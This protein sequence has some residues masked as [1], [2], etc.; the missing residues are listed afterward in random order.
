MR[1]FTKIE[2]VIISAESKDD[3]NK[4][5]EALG[6]SGY[7]DVEE[8]TGEYTTYGPI[9]ESAT[10]CVYFSLDGGKTQEIEFEGTED[11]CQN[12]IEKQ[13]FQCMFARY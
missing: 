11:E 9:R 4:H 10:H 7:S 12:Y 5:I 1:Y 8:L 6:Y 2:D 3:I 13:E